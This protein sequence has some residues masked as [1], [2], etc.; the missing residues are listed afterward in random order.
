MATLGQCVMYG[1]CWAMSR[2]CMVETVLCT[3]GGQTGWAS[4]CLIQCTQR[5]KRLDN[6]QSGRW[7]NRLGPGSCDCASMWNM[8]Y[9][10]DD[11]SAWVTLHHRR[12]SRHCGLAGRGEP[13]GHGR[14]ME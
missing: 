8:I 13:S 7:L 1:M 9:T 3:V 14:K 10:T 11:I 6:V 12:W 5:L 4:V 2:V